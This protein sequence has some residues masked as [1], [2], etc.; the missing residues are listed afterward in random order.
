M[1]RNKFS[2]GLWIDDEIIA[3]QRLTAGQKMILA[4][5]KRER[6]RQSELA[7]YIKITTRTVENAFRKFRELGLLDDLEN[8]K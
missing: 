6:L 8:T 7:A 4:M 2:R 1:S 3:D 5:Y